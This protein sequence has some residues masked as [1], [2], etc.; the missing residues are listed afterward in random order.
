[1]GMKS[2]QDRKAEAAAEAERLEEIKS[3]KEEDLK[4]AVKS[5]ENEK[6]DDQSA[7]GS[8]EPKFNIKGVPIN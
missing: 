4:A 3:K 7:G 8:G 6:K 5:T 1:M 2:F